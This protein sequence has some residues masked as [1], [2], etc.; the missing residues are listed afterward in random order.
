MVVCEASAT[1][2]FKTLLII[3]GVIVVLRFVG[4]LMNA[5][6]NMEEERL[7]NKRERE[8]NDEKRRKQKNL[9]K[10]NILRKQQRGSGNVE[11]VEFE[12]IE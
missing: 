3:I 1:G 11:D 12:E 8:Y 2:V 7:I 5:K 9:G 10:T 6:R 4:Q